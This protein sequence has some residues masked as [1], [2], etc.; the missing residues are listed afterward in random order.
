MQCVFIYAESQIEANS[1]EFF[2]NREVLL[3]I[4]CDRQDHIEFP[5]APFNITKLMEDKF[6]EST[7]VSFKVPHTER[8][9]AHLTL[10]LLIAAY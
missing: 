10:F 6:F 3:Q 2:N 8:L 4:N 7:D 5:F 1:P 9:L